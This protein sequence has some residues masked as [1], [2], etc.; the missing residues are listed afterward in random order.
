MRKFGNNLLLICSLTMILGMF[1]AVS[2]NSLLVVTETKDVPTKI[3]K[4]MSR[5]SVKTDEPMIVYLDGVE[6]GRTQGNQVE[7]LY[8]VTPGNHEIKV[9]NGDGKS[10]TKTESFTKGV[11]HCICLK[12]NRSEIRTPCPYNISVS[13]PDKV[14]E[15]DLVTFA[16]LNSVA[17][18]TAALNYIWSV[19]PD[20]AR[21]TSGLG[22]NSITIDTSGLGNQTITAEVDVADGYYDA[23][24]RQRISV[25]TVVEKPREPEKRKFEEFDMIV[26]KVFDDDKIRLDNYAIGLQN[27]VDGF[28]Y[29]IIYQGTGK[30]ALSADKMA[31]RSLDYLVKNRGIDPSRITIIQGGFRQQTTAALY[32]VYPGGEIPIPMPN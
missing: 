20:N 29:M 13:G 1:S 2:A 12:T 26:F 7:F 21:V 27:R 9:V 3:P 30:K 16:A 11:K 24:C 23:Q 6:I 18:S 22:T 15:G 19:K 31:K 25:R 8:D 17:G 32:F 10:F 4:G 28:G 5:L 14:T